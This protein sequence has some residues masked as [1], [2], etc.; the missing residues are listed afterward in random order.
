MEIDLLSSERAPGRDEDGS[1]PVVT[2]SV[3]VERKPLRERPVQLRLCRKAISPVAVF[4]EA[5]V[6]RRVAPHDDVI[7]I[8]AI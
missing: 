4:L 2:V 8:S 1:A 6:G 3:L 7:P 5:N